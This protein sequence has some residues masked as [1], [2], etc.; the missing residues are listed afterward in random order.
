M[1]RLTIAEYESLLGRNPVEVDTAA[2]DALV[3]DK[4][5]LVTGAGG[6][7]GSE[8]CRQAC[9]RGA[10]RVVLVDQS[11][12]GL[13]NIHRELCNHY[14]DLRVD[15]RI[16]DV[17]D[18]RRMRAVF[19]EERPDIILHAAAYKHVP[20]MERSA[21]EAFVNNV[22]GTR[23]VADLSAAYGADRFVLVSTDKAVTP[24]SIMGAT[25]HLAELYV[26]GLAQA[27]RT[28]F[29]AVRFGNVLGSVGSVVPIFL[30]QIADGGPVTV[31]HPDMVRY[32]MTIPEAC[33][34]VL[35]TS[36]MGVGGEVFV[37]DMGQPIRIVDLAHDL[38]RLCG[39]DPD[40]IG[41]IY[42]GIRPGEK[43]TEHLTA[44]GGGCDPTDQ[45]GIFVAGRAST[46]HGRLLAVI[47]EIRNAVEDGDDGLVRKLLLAENG[48]P[49]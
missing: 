42:T 16:G 48:L 11:E 4:V 3:R 13:F 1:R 12:D 33:G 2:I 6:S 29:V 21:T 32:F 38:I 37:L 15:P 19:S 8:L 39:A 17:R 41:V 35:R 36:S 26:R 18:R 46:H 22:L 30:E 34:L 14:S 43:L 7:I 25:K 45:P 40:K 24:A 47:E 9:A 20:M 44:Q 23:L 31:T 27:G 49:T 10:G 28:R 5:V